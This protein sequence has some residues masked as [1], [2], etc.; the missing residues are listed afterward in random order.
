MHYEKLR[1]FTPP[2]N[3]AYVY[4]RTLM[5]TSYAKLPMEHIIMKQIKNPLSVAVLYHLALS[6][7]ILMFEC[8]TYMSIPTSCPL[9]GDPLF[10]MLL[11]S[12]VTRWFMYICS[13]RIAEKHAMRLQN[14]QD[15]H[16]GPTK[17]HRHQHHYHH[18]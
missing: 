15:Y 14:R 16:D 18:R 1:Y 4:T 2:H 11:R 3:I 17:A 8:V 10:P 5:D 7:V 9:Y 12:I 13:C 6:A